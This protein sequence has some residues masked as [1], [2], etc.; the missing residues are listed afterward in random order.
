M[1][2][3]QLTKS[4]YDALQARPTVETLNGERARADK[5]E[6]DLEAVEADVVRLTTELATAVKVAA[7]FQEAANKTTLSTER[8]GKLGNEFLAKLGETTKARI[9]EQAATMQDSEWAERLAELAELV[10]V[11]ADAKTDPPAAG[12][13]PVAPPGTPVFT[14]EETARM[15]V[16]GAGV[17]DPTPSLSRGVIE[18]LIRRPAPAKK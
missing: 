3:I 7:D 5:A 14:P 12:A 15:Q 17:P 10:G 18:G 4:D 8:L 2:D 9:N 13:P 16:K 6:K 1:D 11:A